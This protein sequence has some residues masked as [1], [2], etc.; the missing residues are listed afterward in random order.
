MKECGRAVVFLI[1]IL[2]VSSLVASADDGEIRVAIPIGSYELEESPQG[3]DLSV[4]NFGRLLVPGKPNLP[5]KIFSLAIPPGA[6]VAEVVFDLGEGVVLPGT[7][8]ISPSPLPRVIGQ[9]DPQLYERDRRRYEEN[10]NS[11]YGSDQPYPASVG[12]MVRTAGFRKY[13]LVDVR[14]T[15][16]IYRPLSGQLTYY[17]QV[18][19]RLSYT[20]P[21]DFS[22]GDIMVD[23]LP[24][25]ERIAQKI[26]LNYDQ[27]QSWYP[28]GKG[29]KGTYDFVIITLDALTSSVIPL[30]NWETSKGRNVNI[31]TTSWINSNYTGYDLA[32]KMRNFLRE[33]YPSEEWGIEDVLLV[34]HYDD[35]PM[36][37]CWQDMG[38][39]KPETDFY[40][41]ELS[42]PDNQS[43]DSD[44]DHRWGENSDP[45][46][47]YSEVNVGRIPWS[48]T[49]NVLHICEK[50]VAYEQNDDPAF[51]KNI[52]LLGAFFWDNDPNPRTDNAVLMEAKVDQVWMRDWTM[53]RM[54]EQG[55]SSFPMDYNLTYNNVLSVWSS[56]RFAFVNWAGHGSPTSSHIYH[57]TGEA[58]VS[59]STCPSLNDDYPS[60]CFADACSNSDTDYL[61]LGQAML[62]QG[63][64]GFVGATKVAL[65]CPG[66]DD[67]N[68]GSGQSLDY[69][70]TTCVTSGEYTQGEALQWSL[71]KMYT[72]GLWDYLKYETFEWGALWGNPDLGMTAPASLSLILPDGAPEYIEP[73]VPTSITVRIIENGDSY[74]PG[75]GTLH[76]RYDGGTYLT[77][78]FSPLGGDL[79]E[80]P[81][82]PA[83]CEDVPEYYFSAEGDTSGMLYN[84]YDA[85]A[86]VYSSI[87]GG[88]NILFADDFETDLGW[89]VE[90]DP[91]LT[92]GPWERGIPIGG[93][94]RGDP[95]TDFDGSGNCYLTDNE[96]GNSDVDDGIT[97]LISPTLNLSAAL[98]AE[99][100]YALWYTNNNGADPNN[101]LFKVYV[102]NDDG[103]SWVLVETIGPE[104]SGGWKE[105]SF[106]VIDFVTPNHLVKVRFEAS[107]LNDGSVVEA[108]IDAFHVSVFECGEII[109]IDGDGDGYGDPGHPE[110]TCPDDN[111]PLVYNPSQADADGDGA[112]DVCDVCTDTDGDGYGNPGFHENTCEVD[113][114]PFAYNPDQEDTDGDLTGDSCDVC[115]NH[116]E[117]DC[118]NPAGSNLPPELTSSAEAIAI[119]SPNIPFVYI[120]T[121][122]DANCDGTE[123]IISF[124]DI[125]SWC[126]VS[127][128]TLSGMVECDYAD[129]SF[130]MSAS[131]GS[132][133][134]T[135]AVIVTIDHSNAAP[136]ITSPGDTVNVAFLQ[137]F[138]Y[139]PAIVDPDD[140]SHQV[141]YPEYPHWCSVQND[142]VFG[143]AP[144]TAFLETLTVVAEDYCNA[145]TLSFVVRT[146]LRG[147]VNADGVVD[148]GDVV[149]LVSYLYRDGPA[150]DPQGAGDVNCDG[151]ADVGDV[152]Y[153]I[154]YLYREG[155]PPAC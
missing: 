36:R 115:P 8:R 120:A 45:I 116:P 19:V 142:S 6:E 29:G 10:Y 89:T 78:P 97:W 86:N 61:N 91:Y 110:N 73:G 92:D 141:T 34:G 54:Y 21:K 47:F 88:L 51:K 41:A 38:Y 42:K 100:H 31:V 70:F 135:Q 37:R 75:T 76:Y 64:V 77:S 132:L 25:K 99:I 60:I 93:G 50:S 140:S 20:Y 114:C 48:Q 155:D 74:I 5:S 137:S 87:V 56:E 26:I 95:P 68:D 30:A 32:E 67:P 52:L 101:D 23:N 33:K 39:G 43:W 104:T 90:N 107:D 3:Q 69:Y 27:A 145:D 118:C 147:D 71:M 106:K 131:D 121:A 150:P 18:T 119:P 24:R 28:A 123:L 124:Y 146:Y 154:N 83:E 113:N 62:Q 149:H 94:D 117:D 143:T 96:D 108:G 17:P 122:S 105:K 111:C 22:P 53:T 112:G 80:A 7:Y 138:D 127:G 11:V 40:Y 126:T 65:G 136:S 16:F 129:T 59:T 9:E 85:P 79:Y 102:S 14:I 58:F 35:V 109:C 82:P 133:A 4:D 103:S 55:Y 44:G 57:G 84:P 153:L 125:P 13:N 2:M 130:K 72:N 134:D 49:S 81:L 151:Q 63:A 66:W 128:D 148:V 144:D 46:D 15:P 1:T 152:V 12:E 98:D 139:Y